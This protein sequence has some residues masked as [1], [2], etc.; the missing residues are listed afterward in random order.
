M[1]YP[2]GTFD[3]SGDFRS[4]T[5]ERVQCRKKFLRAFPKAFKD[6]K[7]LAW[8]RDYKVEAHE[9]WNELLGK[10]EYH[11]LIQA[12]AYDEV[13][14]RALRVESRTNLLF[15]FEKM[16]LRDAV[17]T[18]D[19]A[20]VFALGLYQWLHGTRLIDERF[21]AFVEAVEALPRRQTRVLTWPLVSVFGFI[22]QPQAHLFLKPNITKEAAKVYHFPFAYSS[23]PSWATYENLLEFAALVKDDLA[24]LGPRDM[25]DVQSFI[26]VLGSPFY[27]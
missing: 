19:G 7:F 10:K 6:P 23:R 4:F 13:A 21:E 2:A 1:D 25:I 18:A 9:Q 27:A 20:R 11:R 24:D 12:K 5:K 22:A 16:A 17:R 14:R 8:E 3:H 26:F 15:S